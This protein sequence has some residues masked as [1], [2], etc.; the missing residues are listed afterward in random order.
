MF[1]YNI[2]TRKPE[3][4]ELVL[5]KIKNPHSNRF[6]FT[7]Q[8]VCVRWRNENIVLFVS[9]MSVYGEDSIESWISLD[10]FDSLV[11]IID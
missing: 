4:G 11:K 9:G 8:V 10:E 5:V 2:K 3:D 6:P 1:M 7:Y